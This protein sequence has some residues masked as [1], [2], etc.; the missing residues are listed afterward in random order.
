MVLNTA[1]TLDTT[2]A[3]APAVDAPSM[4]RL[5]S[6][7]TRPATGHVTAHDMDGGCSCVASP[8]G[9]VPPASA[10]LCV[11]VCVFPGAGARRLGRVWL[12][13]P[14]RALSPSPPPLPLLF[15]FGA[16]ASAVVRVA[17]G[18]VAVF[19]PLFFGAG[20]AAV[21]RVAA[22]AAAF[23]VVFCLGRALLPWCVRLRAPLRFFC[24]GLRCGLRLRR[25][26]TVLR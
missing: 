11:C 21:V 2:P 25:R 5:P 23:F 7:P 16:G 17:A 9:L 18:A 3:A 22:G 20:A 6:M 19:V 8:L 14:P 15:F 13:V 1:M 10:R 4:P 26:V 12:L 24:E